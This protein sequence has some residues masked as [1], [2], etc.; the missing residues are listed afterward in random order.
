MASYRKRENGLWEYRISYKTIDG[1]YKR[2]EKGGFKTKKLA[3]AAAIE[4]EKKLTQNI[5]TNDEVTLYDFVKTWSEVYK[6]PYVKDKTWETYSKNFKHIKNYFQELKV[7]DITPLYYQK[8]L[9]EFGEKYAQETLEKFHYQIKGAMKVAVREQVVTFN[10]AEGAKVKSQVEPKNEEEDFLEEREYKALLA[11][12]RE[13]IQYVSYFTLY[14]LAVTGLRFSEAMGLTWSDIDFK[15]GIL[16]IN[17]SFDYSNTQDFAD[18]KN[19]SSKRKVPID[20]NT[21]DILREYK[22]N[23]WQANIKN[24]VCFG[25]SNSACNKLIKKIVGRKVRNHSLRHTY[26]S[27]LILNGV[28]IVTISKL[29]GHES[30]DITLKVYTHQMEALAE[31]NFEKIKNIFLVA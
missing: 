9:N 18:L 16:D 24:R 19:E 6:R 17:K 1:K 31:R 8:K 5:L 28:D 22:K 13:N 21:I 14:L 7:K 30:P 29:L 20:S 2:K 23:H 3:Q 12:T 4:I 11:L 15:N 26:A 27:F 25:V 10:F